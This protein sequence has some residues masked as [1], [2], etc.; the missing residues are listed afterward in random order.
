MAFAADHEVLLDR[1]DEELRIAT[2]PARHL[3]SNIIAGACTRIPVLSKAGKATRIDRLIETGA[4]ADAAL[5]LIELELPFWSV[6]RLV[7]EDGEWL[8]SL[9]R[10]PTL[11]VELDDT[12]DAC[13]GL[14][15]MAILRAFVEARRR[16]GIASEPKLMAPEVWPTADCIV[17]CD[18]FA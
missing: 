2:A 7:C 4:W 17:C 3:L 12:V 1:L 16:G 9:S 15:S 5:A 14:L 18:N 11:P 13:H 8:C 10:Q 6:R